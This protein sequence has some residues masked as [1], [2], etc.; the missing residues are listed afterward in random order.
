MTSCPNPNKPNADLGLILT[1]N[2]QILVHRYNS[3]AVKNHVME[4]VNQVQQ[5]MDRMK[6]TC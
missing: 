6:Q 3:V 2:V 4:T 5:V 1:M